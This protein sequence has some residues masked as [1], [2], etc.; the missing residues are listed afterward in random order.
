MFEMNDLTTME[1]TPEEVQLVVHH[2][3]QKLGE[4][5]QEMSDLIH[6]S[7]LELEEYLETVEG[8]DGND[9]G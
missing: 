2:R 4:G 3:M 7:T 5:Y 9:I 8:V 6:A 1:L